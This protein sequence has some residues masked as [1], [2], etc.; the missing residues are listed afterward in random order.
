MVVPTLPT[1]A[2]VNVS[3]AVS[4]VRVQRGT[5]GFASLQQVE[6]SR[7]L[8]LQERHVNDFHTYALWRVT[9]TSTFRHLLAH[10]GGFAFALKFLFFCNPGIS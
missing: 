10:C 4:G 2:H 8:Q 9:V 1:Q 5:G 3:V 7:P 6:A